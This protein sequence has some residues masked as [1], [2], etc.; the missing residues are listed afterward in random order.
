MV[1]GKSR[2]LS[3]GTGTWRR[4]AWKRLG[5]PAELAKLSTQTICTSDESEL[6][7]LSEQVRSRQIHREECVW[8]Y[9][10]IGDIRKKQ[11]QT[12]EAFANYKKVLDYEM[13]LYL[14]T[15][16]Y[17][18]YISDLTEGSERITNFAKKADVTTAFNSWLDK[19]GSIEDI[20]ALV[21][22]LV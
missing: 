22:S 5:Y 4:R 10:L 19:Y 15:E 9:K 21:N 17:R 16:M 6:E 13:P 3:I 1:S 14:K 7:W 18:I 8:A 2:I 11:G 20:K 12:R